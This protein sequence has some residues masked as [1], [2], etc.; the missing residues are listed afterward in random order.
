MSAVAKI[1][2]EDIA[3][4]VN[5]INTELDRRAAAEI[6]EAPLRRFRQQG[7]GHCKRGPPNVFAHYPISDRLSYSSQ[8]FGLT[9]VVWNQ[10]Y[11]DGHPISFRVTP[12][13]HV[14]PQIGA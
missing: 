8:V 4:L 6:L 11:V 1:S 5:A 7:Q 9:T 14:V 3:R 2:L 10:E 13:R 12:H